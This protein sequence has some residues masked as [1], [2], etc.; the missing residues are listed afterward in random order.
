MA[1]N[2][3]SSRLIPEEEDGE[4]DN[5]EK[6]QILD[7]ERMVS[8]KPN[9]DKEQ[10]KEDKDKDSKDKGMTVDDLFGQWGNKKDEKVQEHKKKDFG[11]IF[12]NFGQQQQTTKPEQKK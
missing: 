6:K 11:D 9:K 3:Q 1:R 5:L 12:A 10:G 7:C 8:R 4:E 2:A